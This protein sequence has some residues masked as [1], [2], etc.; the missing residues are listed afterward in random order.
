[1][2][3]HGNDPRGS[4]NRLDH[5]PGRQPGLDPG[6]LDDPYL[7]GKKDRDAKPP[8]LTF[9][10]RQQEGADHAYLV[11]PGT[12]GALATA[13]MHIMFRDGY[14][15]RAYMAEF[16]DA[17]TNWKRM[18]GQITRMGGADY[19]PVRHGDRR[20]GGAL[21]QDGAFLH[22]HRLRFRAFAERGGQHACGDV[23][24]GHHW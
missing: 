13:L 14:A 1:M 19:R 6:Q 22:P 15:D 10:R 20:T 18:C 17:P 8:W 11:R 3:K 2:A 12:D 5:C 24:S 9:T 21:R 4:L 7:E 23:S 16:A